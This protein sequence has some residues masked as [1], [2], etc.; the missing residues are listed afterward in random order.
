M[1]LHRIGIVG[2]GTMGQGIAEELAG[3]GYDVL[4]ADKTPAI[5]EESK[6]GIEL[7]LD[8]KM[9]KWAITEAEKRVALGRITLSTQ[10]MD[11]GDV[12]FV[13]ET[14][15]EELDAKK[16]LFRTLDQ[17]CQKGVI[18]ASNT[19]TLSITEMGAVTYRSD[20]TIG[21]HFLNPVS[22]G[23]VEIIR[24][25]KTSELTFKTAR[26]FVESIGKTGVEVFESPGFITT[27][28]IMPLLNESMYALME[29]VAS[30]EGIDTAMRLGYELSRGP[31]EMADRMG[32][33]SVLVAM[34]RLFR[35][36]GDLKFR[37]CPLLRKLV[38]A[39][40]LGVKT[41]QGFFK[42]DEAGN[43][44]PEEKIAQTV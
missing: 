42:Y 38:R 40:H 17:I 27:R 10:L 19:S 44:L 8:R 22:K 7:I 20:R 2:A 28:L 4:L 1:D 30:A 33:D 25:L 43:K 35:D 36:F 34:E 6:Q 31:L 24:G 18:F 29:G 3:K 13:I 32:L 26:E 21:L 9:E 41:G 23:V 11:L 14:I 5:L 16:E 37:P 15:T 39:N 12:E